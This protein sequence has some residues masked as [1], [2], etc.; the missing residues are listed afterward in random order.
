[1]A[2][3]DTS[4]LELDVSQG[5]QETGC[6]SSSNRLVL[7]LQL[8]ALLLLPLELPQWVLSPTP[9]ASEGSQP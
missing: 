7:A 8:L 9:A 2:N 5:P 3:R 1:M 4:V 6:H